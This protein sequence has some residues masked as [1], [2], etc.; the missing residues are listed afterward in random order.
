M[1]F[2]YDWR[3]KGKNPGASDLFAHRS[4]QTLRTSESVW[5]LQLLFPYRSL[6]PQQTSG[7]NRPE[8][9]QSHCSSSDCSQARGWNAEHPVRSAGGSSG[10]RTRWTHLLFFLLVHR[11]R[12]HPSSSWSVESRRI[13]TESRALL[14]PSNHPETLSVRFIRLYLSDSSSNGQNAAASKWS[15]FS[16]GNDWRVD[17]SIT[18][19]FRVTRHSTFLNR[20]RS[21]PT[22]FVFSSLIVS[23]CFTSNR[24]SPTDLLQINTLSLGQSTEFEKGNGGKL[25]L[26]FRNDL[27]CPRTNALRSPGVLTD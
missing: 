12:S 17:L 4:L 19:K 22:M 25:E 7:R 11:N 1:C 5:R 6:R 14:T 18:S 2:E 16:L 15:F 3:W 8:A 21:G 23:G 13:G 27:S 10:I 24:L 9:L 20:A 26:R